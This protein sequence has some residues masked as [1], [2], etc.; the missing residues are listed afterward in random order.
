MILK[1][2][3]LVM[4]LLLGAGAAQAGVLLDRPYGSPD[5]VL[6]GTD[7]TMNVRIARD[8]TP[9]DWSYVKF[10][11]GYFGGNGVRAYDAWS[12]T[13]KWGI[14]LYVQVTLDDLADTGSIFSAAYLDSFDPVDQETNYIGD[15]G[16]SPLIFGLPVSYQVIVPAGSNFVVVVNQT[17]IGATGL[18]LPYGLVVEAYSSPFYEAL[19]AP[20]PSTVM[21]SLTG[22]ALI[23]G[24]K[25]L[26]SYFRK[27]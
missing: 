22:L 11:P 2:S 14:D 8:G 10:F 6:T 3:V 9:S 25:R 21:L 18:P 1:K 7:S 19:P 4:G 12:F 13:N 15:A 17:T 24:R 27:G 23:G 26:A 5:T 20:E 16:F